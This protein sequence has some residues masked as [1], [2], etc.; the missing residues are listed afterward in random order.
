M[1]WF[2]ADPS[3]CCVFFLCNTL[4]SADVAVN[5]DRCLGDRR[6]SLIYISTTSYFRC[7]TVCKCITLMM[8]NV[9]TQMYM[10]K[11]FW[12]F[13]CLLY[14]ILPLWDSVIVSFHSSFSSFS[15]IT[16]WVGDL[17]G[18]TCVVYCRFKRSKIWVVTVGIR[19]MVSDN[20]GS[21]WELT[22]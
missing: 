21:V 11:C 20:L 2:S 8:I 5:E 22:H 15:P 3:V 17:F 7:S 14:V 16:I 9:V 18:S 19:A 1:R 6:R 13:I 4:G 12:I 10:F